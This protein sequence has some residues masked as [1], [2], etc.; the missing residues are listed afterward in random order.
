MEIA[1][2]G[3]GAHGRDLARLLAEA[4]HAVRLQDEDATAAMDAVDDV[5]RAVD[6]E[7]IERLDATTDREA[8][9]ADAAIV[10]L[11]R[12][13]DPQTLREDLAALEEWIDRDA[14]LAITVGE[15]SV[16]VA[17]AGLRHPDRAIGLE[18]PAPLGAA[19]AELV[20]ADQTSAETLDRMRSFVED[21]GLVAALVADHPGIVS[22]RLALATEVEA[23]RILAD[24]VAAVAD[25]D[26]AFAKR[27]GHQM[28]PLERADRAGLHNRLATLETLADALGP[29]FEPPSILR[30][31]VAE[32]D[33]GR[34]SG[35]GF[36][37]WKNGEAVGSALPPP[38]LVSH[39]SGPDDPERN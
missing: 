38:D 12:S 19:V 35:R 5:E 20:V 9:V 7:T 32:G 1:V 26:D 23:M 18:L 2:L 37:E 13:S 17:A 34:S 11:A 39:R 30:D 28:G 16:T 25:V 14:I 36:Y 31:L 15:G 3:A 10:I 27:H 8:A 29:R 24:G 4:G 33:V 21:L 22:T 6:E